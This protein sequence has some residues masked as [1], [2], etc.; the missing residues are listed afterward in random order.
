M[1]E[2]ASKCEIE[3]GDLELD[4]ERAK[5]ARYFKQG[6]IL[7]MYDPGCLL[8]ST[9]LIPSYN[10]EQEWLTKVVAE[11][12]NL[13]DADRLPSGLLTFAAMDA[14]EMQRRRDF[15]VRYNLGVRPY[16]AGV[17]HARQ[18]LSVIPFCAE[19]EM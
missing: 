15:H 6:A 11:A 2:D 14:N 16:P 8:P 5:Q 18:L 10:R 19:K 13:S 17:T 3:R 9:P 4:G 1:E 7:S 12:F